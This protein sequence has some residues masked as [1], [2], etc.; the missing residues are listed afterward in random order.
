MKYYITIPLP[1]EPY[2]IGLVK[3]GNS[4]TWKST[5]STVLEILE[6]EGY[7]FKVLKKGR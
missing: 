5:N 4:K 3:Q 1:Q 7:D 6:E 2:N